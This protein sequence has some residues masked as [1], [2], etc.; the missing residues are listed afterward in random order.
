MNRATKLL[1]YQNRFMDAFVIFSSWVFAYFL[2][3]EVEIG[4]ETS[5]TL[6][7]RY[8]G[9]GLLLTLVCVI[10]FKNTKVYETSKFNS[11]TKELVNLIKANFFAF[12]IFIAI[13]FFS[14]QE[15]ISR[16][17]LGF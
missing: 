14:T 13:S 9:Y 5:S 10:T 4:G 1:N 16:I 3:F 6:L 8:L 11:A 12:F 7:G 17:L 15:R 2:R